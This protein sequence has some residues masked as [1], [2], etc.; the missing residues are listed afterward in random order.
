LVGILITAYQSQITSEN[1]ANQQNTIGVGSH[2]TVIKE[3]DPTGNQKGVYSI[4]V[5]DLKNDDNIKANIVEP[6]GTTIITRSITKSPI[7][8]TF[9]II[10]P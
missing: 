3:M 5:T 7:Q 2:M 8:E 6:T 10:S 1:L 4:Q 9:K